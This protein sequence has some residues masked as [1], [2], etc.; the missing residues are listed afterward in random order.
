MKWWNVFKIEFKVSPELYSSKSNFLQFLHFFYK[1]LTLDTNAF[2]RG[3]WTLH[4][5]SNLL[6]KNAQIFRNRWIFLSICWV[7]WLNSTD[8]SFLGISE[9]G[10][11]S[12][13]ASFTIN[14][15][16]QER[17]LN[18]QYLNFF[19]TFISSFFSVFF[20]IQT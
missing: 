12:N 10:T 13:T 2:S 11:P 19:L 6:V 7:V 1:N 18:C 20:L 9:K 4:F 14:A 3:L 17:F 8:K 5:L 15:G 16:K